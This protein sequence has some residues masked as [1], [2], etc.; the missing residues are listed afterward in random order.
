MARD[1]GRNLTRE[2][3]AQLAARL[4]AQD[5]IEDYALAKRKAARHAG[6]TESSQ[7]PDNGEIE[8]ALRS[9]RELYQPQHPAQLRELRQRALELMDE[10]AEFNPHLTGSV[11]T[12]DAGQFAGIHLQLFTDNKKGI[13]HYLLNRGIEF[14]CDE[15]RLYA[16][17]RVIVVPAL[18]FERD[19]VGVRI[20]LLSSHDQ[21][22]QL[23][24]NPNGRPI[25]RAARKAVL[26]LITAS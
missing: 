18:L 9:Y 26:G 6:V 24:S 7:L 11:L 25:A 23:K 4:M 10:L 1:F 2:R 3:I 13:E 15:S 5:G 19:D 8:A 20:T 17:D 14:R 21:R 22:V 16:G 12:G